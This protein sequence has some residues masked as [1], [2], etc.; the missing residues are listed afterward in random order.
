MREQTILPGAPHLDFE[1][2]DRTLR[3]V[4]GLSS[5]CSLSCAAPRSVVWQTEPSPFCA[6]PRDADR[7]VPPAPWRGTRRRVRLCFGIARTWIPSMPFFLHAFADHFAPLAHNRFGKGERW[8]PAAPLHRQPMRPNRWDCGTPSTRLTPP[9]PH[10]FRKPGKRK[11][12]GR[13]NPLR[14]LEIKGLGPANSV[15]LA[16]FGT[17]APPAEASLAE[18]G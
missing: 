1:M 16:F 3:G 7:P 8:R 13:N 9:L 10:F 15:K 6:R 14:P 4:R 2:W 11:G 5:H 17:F 18:A 12:L